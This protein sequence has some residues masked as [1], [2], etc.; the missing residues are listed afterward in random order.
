[1]SDRFPEGLGDLAL[2][3]WRNELSGRLDYKEVAGMKGRAGRPSWDEYF[4]EV[5][6]LVAKR[7]TCL[8]RHVG[9]VAVRDRRILATGYNGAPSGLAHCTDTGCLREKL[10]VPSGQ[11][12][13]LCRALHAEQNIILQCVLHKVDLKDCILYVINQP[14]V[15]CTKM[16]IGV[17]IKKI[18]I[19]EGYPDKLARQ[20]LKEAG[21]TIKRLPKKP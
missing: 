8:R 2:P 13:E 18:V 3:E 10:K 7:S 21:I 19:E 6:H 15:I 5:A 4:L 12:Q 11:R 9:A 14:C 20:M 1:M 17:G 16:L